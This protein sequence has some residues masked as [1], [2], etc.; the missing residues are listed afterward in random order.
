M[1]AKAFLSIAAH[2]PKA[3][4]VLVGPYLDVGDRIR[5]APRIRHM[6]EEAG[7]GDRVVFTGQVDNVEEYMKASDLLLFASEREGLPNV[8][9]ESMA[10]GLPVIA[11]RLPGTTDF[12]IRDGKDGLLVEKRSASELAAAAI[13]LLQDE[14]LLKSISREARETAVTRFA[15]AVIDRQYKDVYS[16]LAR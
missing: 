4:L 3:R 15:S 10:T 6:A 14:A 8:V 2:Y 12:I 5:L 7:I 11:F 9:I 16:E 1:L 13:R